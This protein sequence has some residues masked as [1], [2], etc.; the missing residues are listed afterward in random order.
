VDECKPLVVGMQMYGGRWGQVDAMPRENFDS[1]PQA[2][3]TMF[4][5]STG[6]GQGLALVHFSAQG[7][8]F[9]WDRGCV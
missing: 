9:L 3:L 7:K 8:R 2:M 1:F 6:E 5:V 4:T